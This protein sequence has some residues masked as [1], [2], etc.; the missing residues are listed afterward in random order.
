MTSD[1]TFEE[2]VECYRRDIV[3]LLSIAPHCPIANKLGWALMDLYEDEL[4]E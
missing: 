2:K 1:M 4:G 3:A